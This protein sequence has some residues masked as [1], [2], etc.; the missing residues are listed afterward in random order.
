MGIRVKVVE[1]KPTNENDGLP[2]NVRIFTASGSYAPSPA[3]SK[4]IIL[5]VGIG[6]GSFGENLKCHGGCGGS[7]G[8]LKNVRNR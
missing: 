3:T 5:T 7:F 6:A 4:V 1:M 2:L 8:E